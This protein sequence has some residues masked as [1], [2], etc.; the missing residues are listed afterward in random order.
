MKRT[1]YWI[2]LVAFLL[3]IIAR[4]LWYFPGYSTRPEVKTPDYATMKKPVAP[5]Q[6]PNAAAPVSQLG[7]VV[8]FDAMHANQYQQG[9]IQSL[10]EALNLRG[11]RVEYDM[12]YG[13]LEARLR[14]ASAYVIIAPNAYFSSD[15]IRILT[16]FVERGGRLVIFTDA[17]RGTLMYD[18]NTGNEIQ[19]ADSN[20]VNPLLASFG[21][22]VNN[23]YLYNL[24]ENEGNFRNVYFDQFG[25]DALSIGLKRVALYGAHSV[26]TDSGQILLSSGDQ[27]FSSLT[28]VHDP[29]EGGAA[30]SVDGNVLVFG[31]F[32]FLNTPYNEVADNSTLIANIADFLLGGTRKAELANFPFVFSSKTVQVLPTS[33]VQM[34]AEMVGALGRMQSSLRLL[35]VDLKM[36]E[37]A[38]RSG[39]LLVLGTF[40]QSDDLTPF[41]KGFN[42]TAEDF[43]SYIEVPGF[44]KVGRTGNGLLLFKT[45]DQGNTL[46]LLADTTDDVTTLLDTLSGGLYGCVIQGDIGVCSIGYGGSFSD[47]SSGGDYY[48]DTTPTPYAP[49]GEGS[50]TLTPAG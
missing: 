25:K 24:V 15:E 49:E 42:L 39:D 40:T 10:T 47:G 13:T 21:I 3:P 50:P 23:D 2:A 36:V 38:P 35:N 4:G 48:Y 14:Y 46:V 44:G 5:L 8:I 22:T 29:L 43:S 26:K 31:D 37:E 9:E 12:D 17:T 18:Y 7:G 45:S 6:T 41:L 27:T 33:E 28:D 11:A 19:F 34:T 1:W 20:A 30:L 16:G 32:T